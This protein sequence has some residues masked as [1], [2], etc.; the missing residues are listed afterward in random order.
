MAS[1]KIQSDMD[2]LSIEDH[3]ALHFANNA[4]LLACGKYSD[5]IV[6]CGDTEYKLHRAV[7]CPSS[8]FLA[9]ICD[10]AFKVG[11]R[12]S[13]LDIQISD[14]TTLYRKALRVS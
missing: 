3:R 12:H 2:N 13:N 1:S 4:S 8:E 10:G 6:R 5:L 14:Q 7:V 11:K 9:V